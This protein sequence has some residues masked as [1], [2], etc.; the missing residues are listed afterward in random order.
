M[1]QIKIGDNLNNLLFRQQTGDKSVEIEMNGHGGGV[2][3][4]FGVE[5]LKVAL[6]FITSEGEKTMDASQYAGLSEEQL[7]KLQEIASSIGTT[8]NELL[9]RGS[10]DMIIEQYSSKK[11]GLLNE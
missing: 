11:F 8:I 9:D 10:P 3:S 2:T 5:D 1:K 6:R 7:T 4:V